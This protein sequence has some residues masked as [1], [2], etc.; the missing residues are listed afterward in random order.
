M[1]ENYSRKILRDFG[2]LIAFVLPIFIGWF[3]PLLGGQA[4]KYWTLFVAFPFM[5]LAI[6][7]PTL[8]LEPY[9]IWMKIGHILGW[10]NSRVILGFVFLF[11][12]LP[13]SFVMKIF[14]YDPLRIRKNI[15]QY[16]YRENKKGHKIDLKKIF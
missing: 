3:I 13:I 8:L 10:I 16:S 5:F 7:K 1:S 11:V 12:L 15:N 2:L 4:F 9:R 6:F 14:F